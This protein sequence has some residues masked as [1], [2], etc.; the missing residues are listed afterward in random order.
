MSAQP[1]LGPEQEAAH[2]HLRRRGLFAI[3]ALFAALTCAHNLLLP[4]FEGPD[5]A[6]NLTYIRFLSHEQRLPTPSLEPTEELE[7]LPRAIVPPLWFVGMV[8]LYRMSGA[9]D[10]QQT[11]T[12]NP[13]FLR[14]HG[15][16]REQALAEPLGRLHYRHGRD[17]QAPLAG[18]ARDLRWLRLASL[19]WSLLALLTVARAARFLAPREPRVEL[20]AAAL[21]ALTPQFQHLSATLSMDLMLAALGGLTL[22]CALAWCAGGSPTATD[23]PCAGGLPTATESPR[24][25]GGSA[26]R[27]AFGAGAAAGLACL[28]K[29]NGFVLL[30]VLALAAALAWR[31]A[32]CGPRELLAAALGLFLIAGPYYAWSAAA[33]GHPL[34]LWAYQHVSPYHNQPGQA[35]DLSSWSAWGWFW[36]VLFLTW[37]ADFGWTSVWFP[38]AVNALAALLVLAGA[39][40]FALRA[41]AQPRAR[42]G[43]AHASADGDSSAR[44]AWQLPGAGERAAWQLLGASA[45]LILAAEVYFNLRFSQPQARHLYPFLPALVAPLALGLERLRLLGVALG[46]HALASAAAFV[47]LSQQLRPAGWNTDPLWSASDLARAAEPELLEGSAA[48]ERAGIAWSDAAPSGATREPPLLRWE[49]RADW[50]YELV[51]GAGDPHLRHRP[52]TQRGYVLRALRDLGQPVQSPFALPAVVWD[53]AVPGERFYAQLI[54]LDAEGKAVARSAVRSFERGE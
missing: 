15:G 50:S 3:L 45:L 17:E 11:L 18:A 43:G 14:R 1:E 51:L 23:R 10:W 6:E 36:A 5:E 28:V 13:L 49:T 40:G 52:W 26:P 37:F 2:A 20:G 47:L 29:L 46:F 35:A 53:A 33:S 27:A 9:P 8:P 4:L 54:A 44:A 22:C 39:L 24:A 34:W 16:T 25:G 7:L 30:P 31:R 19:P 41:R 21:L 38:A 42:S 48:S 12:L 32:R